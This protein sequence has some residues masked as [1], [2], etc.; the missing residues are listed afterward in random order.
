MH[1]QLLQWFA[2]CVSV[3]FFFFSFVGSFSDD[4][5]MIGDITHPLGLV[6]FGL[7]A[8]QEERYHLK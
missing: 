6:I 2:I 7:Q 8:G 3:A 1:N 5:L 4:N